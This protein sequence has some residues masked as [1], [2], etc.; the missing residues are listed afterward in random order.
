MTFYVLESCH[1]ITILKPLSQDFVPMFPHAGE[2][3]GTLLQ[4]KD[5]FY[6]RALSTRA[7]RHFNRS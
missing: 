1:N 6:F 4:A 3:T 5:S 2:A 7:C